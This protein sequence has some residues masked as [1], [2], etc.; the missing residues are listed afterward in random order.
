MEVKKNPDVPDA[1]NGQKAVNVY[2]FFK[3]GTEKVQA[4]AFMQR[5]GKY[6]LTVDRDFFAEPN[7]TA[8]N[9]VIAEETPGVLVGRIRT[10]AIA[11]HPAQLYESI[12]CFIFFFVLFWL[13]A[14]GKVESHPGLI[15]GVFMVVL[16]TLR[17][18]YEFIKKEQV[19]FETDL[20]LN[21]GQILSIPLAI[22]GVVV[23]IWSNRERKKSLS[24]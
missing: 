3:K 20:V 14:R 21:M 17:F 24:R 4:D 8:L 19:D 11:R 6:Y 22:V 2:V 15:F 5:E 7:E 23:L 16:W 12:S 10:T 13:W 9:Y 1:A 18:L